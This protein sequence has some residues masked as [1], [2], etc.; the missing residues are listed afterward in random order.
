MDNIHKTRRSPRLLAKDEARFSTK[1][2]VVASVDDV[3]NFV[4]VV[5]SEDV[6][7]PTLGVAT[8][9]TGDPQI[10]LKGI[11]SMHTPDGTTLK[12]LPNI[13]VRVCTRPTIPFGT[14]KP[15]VKVHFS[16]HAK[17]HSSDCVCGTCDC[18][19]QL[20]NI[21][22]KRCSCGTDVYDEGKQQCALM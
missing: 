22:P 12:L 20:T 21:A 19:F 11:S 18:A 9:Y 7:N 16:V 2:P 5:R 1:A 17:G 3:W 13:A 10:I 15:S 6:L 8:K 4:M 14:T